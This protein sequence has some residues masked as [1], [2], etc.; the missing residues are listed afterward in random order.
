M[1]SGDTAFG[2][3]LEVFRNEEQAAQSYFFAYLGICSA[4]CDE[5]VLD[6]LNI[7]PHFWLTTKHALLLGTFVALGR[8][9]DQ[10]TRH[11]VDRLLK[12]ASNDLG[13]FSRDGLAHRRQS[14]GMTA[15]RAADYASDK[16]E[17]TA[18]DFRVLRKKVG[19]QR[20]VYKARYK[21]IRDKIFA[22]KELSDEN[23]TS[24][25]FKKTNISEMK[26]ILAFLH[27]LHDALL[28]LLNNGRKPVLRVCEFDLE[29]A[30]KVS[31]QPLKPGEKIAREIAVFLGAV[32]QQA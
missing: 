19:E 14:E 3:E 1:K 13:L 30:S 16:Y 31:W 20:R 15:A 2:K 5:R 12:V 18:K 24:S 23:D 21:D 32:K 26:A 6:S 17:P 28:Q 4:T 29:P 25:L 11:N 27:A 22:H 10:N 8:I 7:A 9:F